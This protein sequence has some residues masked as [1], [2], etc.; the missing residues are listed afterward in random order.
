MPCPC[1]INV[2]SVSRLA[3]HRAAMPNI[4]LCIFFVS[5]L[6]AALHFAPADVCDSNGLAYSTSCVCYFATSCVPSLTPSPCT[7]AALSDD[8]TDKVILKSYERALRLPTS[9]P[10]SSLAK[11]RVESRF[12]RSFWRAFTSTHPLIPLS[13]SPRE[14]LL[15]CPPFPPWNLPSFTVESTLSSSC[16]RFNPL[17]CHQGAAL[18]HLDSLSLMI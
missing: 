9:F 1:A 2:C 6:L 14:A 12:C 8:F 10:I 18:A 3:L 11:L 4:F 13:T 5:L 17:L 15:A 7:V 16:P